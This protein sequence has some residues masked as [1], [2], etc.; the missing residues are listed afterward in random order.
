MMTACPG[1]IGLPD[2]A[3]TVMV[4]TY[5]LVP[6][7]EPIDAVM[8]AS[9]VVLT[10]VNDTVVADEPYQFWHVNDCHRVVPFELLA[11]E[12]GVTPVSQPAST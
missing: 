12:H 2:C 3:V 5:G 4:P 8:V 11:C 9:V 10:P 7:H 6:V 1:W